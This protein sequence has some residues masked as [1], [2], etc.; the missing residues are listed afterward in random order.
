[1]RMVYPAYR[2]VYRK[3]IQPIADMQQQLADMR[4][5]MN[6]QMERVEQELIRLN[7][8]IE[9]NSGGYDRNDGAMQ[10][11]TSDNEYKS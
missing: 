2:P 8:Y 5:T 1:M 7:D 6:N 4:W 9:H 10:D 3:I 11:I